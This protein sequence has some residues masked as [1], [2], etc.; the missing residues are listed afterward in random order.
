MASRSNAPPGSARRVDQIESHSRQVLRNLLLRLVVDYLH[1]HHRPSRLAP[2]QPEA[3]NGIGQPIAAVRAADHRVQ[4][5]DVAVI[6]RQL[7][8]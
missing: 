6:E 3:E 5:P 1:R 7:T 2:G 4:P 8:R